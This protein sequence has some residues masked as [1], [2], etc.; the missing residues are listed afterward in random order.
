MAANLMLALGWNW[1]L[2]IALGA[3]VIVLLVYRS[4]QR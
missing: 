1:W 2:A 3:I 4:R